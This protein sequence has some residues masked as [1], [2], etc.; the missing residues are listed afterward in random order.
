MERLL[1]KLD[2]NAGEN[3]PVI[4]NPSEVDYKQTYK[5]MIG[6]IVPRP[7]AFVSSMSAEGVRNLAPFSYF[8]AASSNPPVILFCPVIRADGAKKDTLNNVRSTGEFV[9]NIVS[10]DFAAAMNVCSADFPP[11]VDEFLESGLTPV[12]SDL[13]KPPRVGESRISME[14]RLRDI[15]IINDGPGGGSIV[16]G[17]ILRFHVADELIENFRIDPDAL[18]A[19]GRMGGPTYVRTRDRFDLARP[20]VGASAKG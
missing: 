6:S 14:C 7:I 15:V 9:V 10:E 4:I 17:D 13:V 20:N 5:L 19:I 1:E 8:T 18:Q 2:G 3:P 12:P 16:L 11:G